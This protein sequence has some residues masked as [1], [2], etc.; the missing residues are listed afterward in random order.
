MEIAYASSYESPWKKELYLS[1]FGGGKMIV[2]VYMYSVCVLMHMQV[3][4]ACLFVSMWRLE[5]NVRSIKLSFSTLSFELG[6]LTECLS[7]IGQT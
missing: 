5:V 3:Q 1:G 6:F 4:V 2:R 7:P